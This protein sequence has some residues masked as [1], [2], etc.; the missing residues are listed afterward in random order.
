MGF[1]ARVRD[2]RF[3]GNIKI[4]GRKAFLQ[5]VKRWEIGRF[6]TAKIEQRSFRLLPEETQDMLLGLGFNPIRPTIF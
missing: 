4:I 5:L 3:R 2:F 1:E 6:M